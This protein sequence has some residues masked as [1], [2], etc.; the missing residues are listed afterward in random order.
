[1]A[2]E[3]FTVASV[4]I[5]HNGK[6]FKDEYMANLEVLVV[7]HEINKPSMFTI[8]MNLYNFEEGSWRGVDLEEFIPGDSV[9]IKMGMEESV[10]LFKGELTAIEPEFCEHPKLVLRGY[11]KMY[12]LNFGAKRRSF[13]DVKDSEIAK[14][15][16][17]ESG[18]SI[19]ADSTDSVYPYVFQ[20]NVSNFVFLQERSK[21]IGFEM[22][23]DGDDLLYRKSAEDREPEF[24]L[25]YGV[26]L[27]RF[28]P[29][30]S[31]LTQGSQVEVRG[32]S[33]EKKEEI[34]SS[35]KDGSANTTM[36]GGKDGY[37]VST[38]VE[39]SDMAVVNDFILDAADGDVVA[40]ARYNTYIKNFITGEGECAGNSRIRAGKTVEIKGLGKKFSGAYYIHFSRHVYNAS[41]GYK[42]IFKVKRTGI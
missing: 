41:T 4:D 15:V 24:S 17:S 35:A 18:L 25:E 33:S 40:K 32:W 28:S 30:L 14:Q 13:L 27:D 10:E 20:N 12:R 38:Q 29:K 21:R 7:E 1:M 5:K 9:E 34:S 6:N 37:Q 22:L 16:G 2:N 3:L 39:K 31:L 26:D 8:K 11:D 42:T 19:K 36:K 23:V